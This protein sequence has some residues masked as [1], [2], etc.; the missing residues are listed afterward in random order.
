MGMTNQV[1][2][3][4]GQPHTGI[5]D[6]LMGASLVGWAAKEPEQDLVPG[7]AHSHD[8]LTEEPESHSWSPWLASVGAGTAGGGGK[9]VL[10]GTELRMFKAHTAA[11]GWEC[12]WRYA[13]RSR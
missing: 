1:L 3:R 6:Q 10:E 2:S 7:T 9:R 11:H 12:E 8:C 13:E 5:L 4:Q